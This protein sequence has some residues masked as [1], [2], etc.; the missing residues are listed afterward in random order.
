MSSGFRR[1][2]SGPT[3]ESMRLQTEWDALLSRSLAD[4]RQSAGR[5]RDGLAALL[6]VV[7]AAV[8]LAGPE[9]FADMV[10][11]WRFSIAGLLLTGL[12]L[13]LAAL[14]FALRATAG[15]PRPLT[16]EEFVGTWKGSAALD[17]QDAKDASE[18]IA[19]A[20]TL[21]GP[22]IAL[23]LVA[24]VAALVAPAAASSPPALV[25]VAMADRTVCGELASGDG[26]QVRV[27][28]AGQSVPEVVPMSEVVNMWV[29][30]DCQSS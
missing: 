25:K 13:T 21:A 16:F 9:Q 27:T 28:V 29:V 18:D 5:W 1:P 23:V 8:V 6:G 20:Q 19:K 14:Y 11:A 7:T 4:V 2:E 30:S 10:P 15:R 17:A 26:G 24:S 22:G 12:L 3:A